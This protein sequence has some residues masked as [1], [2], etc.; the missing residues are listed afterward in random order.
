MSFKKI[1]WAWAAVLSIV[2]L[3]PGSLRADLKYEQ[4]TQVGGTLFE[5]MKKMPII[6][7]KLNMDSTE[8]HYFKGDASSTETFV[9]GKLT[10]GQVIRLNE[11]KWIEID[12]AQKSYSVATFAEMRAKM[13]KAMQDLKKAQKEKSGEASDVTMTPK[14][15]VKD[16]GERKVINGYNTRHFILTMAMEVKDQKSGQTGTMETVTDLWTTKDVKG[17]EEQTQF[18]VRLAEKMGTMAF[19]REAMAGMQ[20]MMADPNMAQG[21]AEMKKELA[22]MEGTPILTVMSIIMPGA[23][24]GSVP[25][26]G[27]KKQAEVDT[28]DANQAAKDAAEDSMTGQINKNIGKVFGGLGGF[29]RKKKKPEPQAEEKPQPAKPAPATEQSAGGTPEPAMKTTVE[30]KSVENGSVSASIFEIPAGYKKTD[31]K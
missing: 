9:N 27:E 21:M 17:F 16:T 2:A 30:L 18:Y 1:N 4:A 22:K 31:F 11:E 8:I 15:T 29:G 7:K 10:K 12:H 5:M 24:A 23:P 20:G 25:P 26:E 14:I 28:P 6:G 19:Y 3:A 13:E